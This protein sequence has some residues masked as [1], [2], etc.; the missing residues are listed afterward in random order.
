[1]S[2]A[3]TTLPHVAKKQLGLDDVSYRAILSAGGVESAKDIKTSAQ[4]NRIM[5][6]FQKA[7]F[8][9]RSNHDSLDPLTSKCY[10][11]WCELYEMGA[12]EDKSLK[13][14]KSYMS[15]MLGAQDIYRNDQKSRVIESLKKWKARVL[16][17]YSRKE[18][19]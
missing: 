8:Q 7:G 16:Q 18:S 6:A 1:M 11:I 12:V 15:R 14:M 9:T 19:L 5:L 17:K 4:F 2:K 3:W 13:A 10:A